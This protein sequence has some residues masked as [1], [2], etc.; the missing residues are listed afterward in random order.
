MSASLTPR[1]IAADLHLSVDT[2]LQHL[3]AGRIPGFQL[4]PNAP[5]RTDPDTYAEWRRSLGSRR[6][7]DGPMPEDPN[8]I[9]PRT[10]RSRA[11]MKRTA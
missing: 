9:E 4:V 1:D 3:R 5:W 8:R 11:R 7:V 6:A 2:V 10:A